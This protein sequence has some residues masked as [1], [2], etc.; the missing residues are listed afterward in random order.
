MLRKKVGAVSNDDGKYTCGQELYSGIV[1]EEKEGRFMEAVIVENGK[2]VSA[3]KSPY[4]FG[5]NPP[6]Q[7]DI[8]GFT[9]DWVTDDENA[10]LS[11]GD[12]LEYDLAYGY[13]DLRFKGEP[14]TGLAYEFDKEDCVAEFC[15]LNGRLINRADWGAAGNLKSLSLGGDADQWYEW[16][17]SGTLKLA[18]VN[19][20]AHVD[21]VATR[22]FDGSLR[23][24]EEGALESV[25][26]DKTFISSLE[27]I[28]RNATHFPVKN[29]DELASLKGAELLKLLGDGV[30]DQL[31]SKMCSGGVL[32]NTSELHVYD[33]CLRGADILVDALA[34]KKNLK[35]VQFESNKLLDT[36]FVNA[37][38]LKG[39]NVECNSWHS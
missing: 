30:D 12:D 13:Y 7:I 25:S 24:S 31:L 15:Y 35:K 3:Y 4:F 29:I 9:E 11:N 21:G 19:R 2:V 1:F 17:A 8:T 14:Y 39:M 6:R 27:E 32:D 34:A 36:E 10:E 38:R 23:F 28:A 33:T 5:E 16:H 18:K 22:V 26:V 37:L 20:T